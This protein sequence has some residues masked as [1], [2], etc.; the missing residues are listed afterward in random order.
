MEIAVYHAE[1]L[2]VAI[3]SGRYSAPAKIKT[4]KPI[5]PVFWSDPHPT[6]RHPAARAMPTIIASTGRPV[7]TASTA[8]TSTATHI[9]LAGIYGALGIGEIGVGQQAYA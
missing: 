9:A 4:G 7:L 3:Y 1:V 5:H 8:P 6:Q 2:T